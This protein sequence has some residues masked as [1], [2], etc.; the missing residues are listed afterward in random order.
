M[1][2]AAF[3]LNE[4]CV[5]RRW[6]ERW[7]EHWPA[8]ARAKNGTKQKHERSTKKGRSL[9]LVYACA[10]ACRSGEIALLSVEVIRITGLQ[11]ERNQCAEWLTERC[12]GTGCRPSEWRS[13]G[14]AR[15]SASE[16]GAGCFERYLDKTVGALSIQDSVPFI[17]A[18]LRAARERYRRA[19]HCQPSAI[20][21][22]GRNLDHSLGQRTSFE[23]ARL[24]G[25]QSGRQ[26]VSRRLRHR[27]CTAAYDWPPG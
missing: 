15:R 3:A 26:S 19:G 11:T 6:L 4:V 20:Y 12:G 14:A 10:P 8:G 2:T 7:L 23:C 22:H 16:Q 18:G 5:S 17:C 25:Y 1:R 9:T 13:V 27:F 24:S 21:A